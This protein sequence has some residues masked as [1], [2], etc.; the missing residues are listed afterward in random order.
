MPL[1]PLF[2]ARREKRDALVDFRRAL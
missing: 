1:Y 2:A